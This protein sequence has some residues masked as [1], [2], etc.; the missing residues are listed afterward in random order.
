MDNFPAQRREKSDKKGEEHLSSSS[1]QFSSAADGRSPRKK[2]ATKRHLSVEVGTSPKDSRKESKQNGKL[3]FFRHQ[4]AG[5]YPIFWK[6]GVI[7]KPI[8]KNELEFYKHIQAKIPELVPFV[9]RYLGVV[10]MDYGELPPTPTLERGS[11]KKIGIKTAPRESESAEFNR[12]NSWGLRCHQKKKESLKNRPGIQYIRLEDLT[13]PFSRPNI[14]DLKIGTRVYGVGDDP[15]KIKRKIQKSA[16]TTS[17]TLGL[18]LCGMQVYNTNDDGYKFH[19]KFFGR[20]LDEK[21]FQRCIEEFFTSANGHIRVKVMRK[22]ASRIEMLLNVVSE[23]KSFQFFSS[24]LLFICEGCLPLEQ[25]RLH[26][27][28]KNENYQRVDLRFIDFAQAATDTE[29]KGVDD[30]FLLG[31]RNIVKIMRGIA[32]SDGSDIEEEQREASSK[33]VNGESVGRIEELKNKDKE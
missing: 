17:R 9:P 12:F 21:G 7:C 15:Q 28:I 19:D 11:S 23:Q 18:R 30:G 25:K 3:A 2:V 13:L 1:T 29:K 16:Q 4:V 31:L 10:N 26:G 22:L 14:L 24:S 27:G 8:Q 5:H 33:C 32:T 6:S 20:N